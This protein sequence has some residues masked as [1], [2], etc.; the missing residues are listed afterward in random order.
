[1]QSST[2]SVTWRS[3]TSINDAM[4]QVPAYEDFLLRSFAWLRLLAANFL[5]GW[6]T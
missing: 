1:M 6:A 4:L 2:A 5:G 3:A